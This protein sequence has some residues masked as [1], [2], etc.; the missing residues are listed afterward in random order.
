MSIQESELFRTAS[1]SRWLENQAASSAGMIEKMIREELRRG[2]FSN[3]GEREK[4]IDE[5][6]NEHFLQSG[7][8]RELLLLAAMLLEGGGETR[9]A[10][11]FVGRLLA[12]KQRFD[13]AFLSRLQRFRIRLALNR[14]DLVEARAEVS[15]IERVVIETSGELGKVNETV[16]QEDV[17]KVTVATWLLSAEVSLAEKKLDQARQDLANAR[18]CMGAAAQN[19]DES[20][21]FELLSALVCVKLDDA[22][23]APALA[24]LYQRH[25]AQ[26]SQSQVQALTSARIAAAAGDMRRVNGISESEALRW[27][28]Y[29]PDPNVVE[30]YLREGAPTDISEGLLEKLPAPHELIA[31]LDENLVEL[32]RNDGERQVTPVANVD[33]VPL[34]FLFEYF[35][36]EE[37]TGMFDYNS[38]TGQLEVDWSSCEEG[39]IRE[40]VEV[41]AVSDVALRCK[42]GTIYLHD[43][44][45]VDASL[46]SSEAEL[47]AMS[48]VDVI[49]ELFRISSARLPGAGVR[50]FQSAAE[51]TR[52]SEVINL[53]PNKL[54]LD[55]A[56]RLDHLRSGKSYEEV[57][58]DEVD[59]DFAFAAWETAGQFSREASEATSESQDSERDV[60]VSV[61][62][63]TSLGPIVSAPDV[64]SLEL[65]VVECLAAAGVRDSRIEIVVTESGEKLRECGLSPALCDVWQTYEVGMC[66]V[67]LA[68]RKGIRVLNPKSVDVIMKVAVQRLRTLPACHL[69][70]K[71]NAPGFIAED[72]RSQRV[73][74]QLRDI[75]VLD[76]VDS[77]DKI[78]HVLLAGERGVGK[79]LLAKL[80]HEWSRRSGET[81]QVINLGGIAR[82]L[83]VSE[84]FG[85]KKGSFTGSVADRIGYIQKAEN[86]TLFVDELDEGSG[87]M[88][89]LLKRVVQFGTYNVVGN[90]DERLCNVR[91]IAATN[92]VLGI[93][94]DLKDR[95]WI[96]EV[97]ALRERRADIAPLA[98][99]F[100]SQHEYSLPE[101][102]LS[103]L[104]GLQWPGNVR[105]LQTLV[106]R[107]CAIA[108]TVDEVNLAAFESAVGESG[109]NPGVSD[110]GTD[111]FP[112]LRIGE[113]LRSRLNA[114][115]Q[116]QIENA[117]KFTNW[118]KTA[119][120]RLLGISRPHLRERMKALGMC[121]DKPQDR[122]D[123]HEKASE[124]EESV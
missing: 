116:W 51:G 45:Y 71:I 60:Q 48:P 83:A 6:V 110:F 72:P 106:H 119:T 33:L 44:S 109:S 21:M 2:D 41:G 78:T 66:T 9:A 73:L 74:S 107:V 81:Y 93:K 31:A 4:R 15:L 3:M 43:G 124:F 57:A 79:E 42:R 117:L 36:L 96:V 75:A 40:A 47:R 92:R 53:R 35:P 84:L 56:R 58:D 17:S 38:K 120:A 111:Q 50:Q 27:R 1:S 25:V 80:I 39:I 98:Q 29:G 69:A 8:E 100:A 102:V 70:T 54:N 20:V 113:T 37:I 64:V 67:G 14:G 19:F 16:D 95:F 112:P 101:A 65:S 122:S 22:G 77:P 63:L 49:F 105:Q 87:S 24:Y 91:F 30:H 114:Q 46:H 55:L 62:D 10:Y 68:L 94:A 18:S 11:R 103:Y 7:H 12:E 32:R 118:N 86:G 59:L 90:P 82:E 104:T 26:R 99:Y 121:M 34:S 23:G 89:A 115:E 108:K 13:Q 28:N 88:Q 52:I 97:P 61:G 5:L 76:G 85:S 123:K